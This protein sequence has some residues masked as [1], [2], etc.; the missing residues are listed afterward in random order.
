MA[1]RLGTASGRIVID[2][3]G[4]SKG[5]NTA[6]AAMSGF[7]NVIDARLSSIK[8]LGQNL[9]KVGAVGA[10]GLGIAI[11]SAADFEERLS[12]IQAV[13]GATAEEMDLISEAALRI[14]KD[15]KFSATESALAMEELVKAGLTTTEVLNGAADATVNLA[16]AG[17]LGFP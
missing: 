5:F 12:A 9:A 1:Y 16:A 14:G 11:N 13:S 2:G 15:T 8:N 3:S 6:G 4:A 7:F 10:A 17:E